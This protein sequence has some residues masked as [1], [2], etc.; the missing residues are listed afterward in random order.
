MQSALPRDPRQPIYLIYSS[1]KTHLCAK[2]YMC[3]PQGE[4]HALRPRAARW[5]SDSSAGCITHL[6]AP[7][8]L[9]V[10][11]LSS[12]CTA[13]SGG[14]TYGKD[15]GIAHVFISCSRGSLI[16]Q[17][18]SLPQWQAIADWN[19]ISRA[20]QLDWRRL[21]I[22]AFCSPVCELLSS[23]FKTEPWILTSRLQSV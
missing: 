9:L 23:N 15:N 7:A 8:Q 4:G 13:N 10:A 14:N 2:A 18:P 5:R 6:P 20:T 3:S 22:E 19:G 17:P 16:L 12:G 21:Y 11:E 1:W